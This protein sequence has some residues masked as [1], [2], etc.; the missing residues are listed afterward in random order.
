M[1]VPLGSKLQLDAM[2][3]VMPTKPT[4]PRKSTR[5]YLAENPTSGIFNRCFNILLCYQ[6][7]TSEEEEEEED[8]GVSSGALVAGWIK[9]SLGWALSEQPMLAGRLRRN[10]DVEGELELV[11]NDSGVRL[12]EGKLDVTL[13]EFLD[14]Q[15]KKNA[16]ADLV[17]WEDLDHQQNPQFS[18]LFYV[19]VTS[20]RCGG[21]SIGISCNILL[22]D[23]FAMISFLKRWTDIHIEM[24]SRTE[25]PKIPIFYRPNL[26][27]GGPSSGLSIGSSTKACSA[28]S[29]VFTIATKILDLDSEIHKK[30]AA[31]C[32]D[33]AE[34]KIGYK[35]APNL[36]FSLMVKE[37]S[38]DVEVRNFTRENLVQKPSTTLNG[39]SISSNWD[40][41][42]ADEICFQEGNKAAHVS[43]WIN[44]V[45]D[46]ALV[47]IIPSPEKDSSGMK[48]VVTIPN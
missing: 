30:F 18:P 22:I 38:E 48:I 47:M 24:V 21:Y 39:F 45:P 23:P 34:Q 35:T 26:R 44:S 36:N 11:S 7:I 17:F 8:S 6:K 42:R 32:I 9:E 16:E 10:Q 13:S 19:Q 20:F 46:E 25:V 12:I 5:I 28:Q 33:E 29:V 4:D 41:L 1:A 2:Q 14:L 15:D 43:C 37:P 40:D 3:T 31:L 27:N